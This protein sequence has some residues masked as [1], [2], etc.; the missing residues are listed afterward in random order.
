VLKY[1]EPLTSDPEPRTPDL[2]Q[3]LIELNGIVKQY[4][5]GATLIPVLKGIDLLVKEGDFVS[6]T[7]TSGSGK[8]T[9]LNILG[10][11]DRPNAGGYLLEGLNIL[12]ASDDDLSGLRAKH[13]GFVFQTFNLIP[14]LDVF[15]NV[16]LP[17]LYSHVDSRTAEQRVR[18][19]VARVG[20]E[21]R[22]NHKPSELSGGEI[23]RAAIAR[24]IAISPKMILADEPTGNLD[25]DTGR[26]ILA[27]FKKFHSKGATIIM[28]T[29]D[30]D[31]A[32]CADT[33]IV[34]KDGKIV[35]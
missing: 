4:Y 7:G 33:H 28:V 18:E 25:F 20:L 24:A 29:H 5:R 26:E 19:A 2:M 12:E 9:L 6:V 15:E 23:Q 10:C 31:V 13:I 30:R 14:S 22:M 35:S 34:L 1:P 17:F 16:G 3:N 8:S 32:A 11:L 27:L 21:H